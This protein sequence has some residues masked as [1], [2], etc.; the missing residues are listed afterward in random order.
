MV[1]LLRRFILGKAAEGGFLL[2]AHH[3]IKHRFPASQL[4]AAHQPH[5]AGTQRCPGKG[6]ELSASGRP[7]D[8]EHP[9]LIVKLPHQV[10][11]EVALPCKGPV[12][13]FEHI[14]GELAARLL[15]GRNGT[16]RRHA[17]CG[18]A[19]GHIPVSADLLQLLNAAVAVAQ[20]VPLQTGGLQWTET[21]VSQPPGHMDDVP[22][23]IR[24]FLLVHARRVAEHIPL[25]G[26]QQDIFIHG[27]VHPVD[28]GL[29][30]LHHI[31]IAKA[32]RA[33]LFHKQRVEHEGIFPVVVEAPPG[34][35]RVVLAG[36]EHH[37]V[38]EL[39]VVEQ[40]ASG[41]VRLFVVPV[42][43]H[44]FF[45]GI[46]PAV[47][48]KTGHIQH[49]GAVALQ[50]GPAVFQLFCVLHA[51]REKVGRGLDIRHA[52]LPVEHEQVH[53]PDGDLSHAAPG[54]RVP[55]HALDP[56]ALL[57]LAPPGVA[58]HLLI[59]CLLQHHRQDAG[60][61]LCG[62]R[63]VCRPGQNIGGRVIVHGIGVLVGN[64]VEQ[65][66]T[67]RLGLALHH[68][69]LVVLPVSHPEPQ[70]VVYNAF[71]QRGFSGLVFL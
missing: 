19:L 36:V 63:I 48:E 14:A 1:A 68:G 29:A 10:N 69:V 58:V 22:A 31:D 5:G 6:Y 25:L 56:G 20:A 2:S 8:T 34:K 23:E 9:L 28:G 45:G 51:Q 67:G 53:G 49:T 35:G 13:T 40:G 27:M 15:Q 33:V 71:V 55:E 21:L 37:T 64:A 50:L 46:Q 4:H 18:A 26:C 17:A 11:D 70:L 60:K 43:H 16:C 41:L 30:F 66:P 57:E 47:V 3:D 65:P 38:A 12:G 24:Q 42:H 61:H 39:A 54:L 44:A 32:R 52:R 62:L 59:V 7:D